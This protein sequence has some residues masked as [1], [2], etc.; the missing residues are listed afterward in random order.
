[1]IGPRAR[2]VRRETRA[3]GGGAWPVRLG[4]A[5]GALGARPRPPALLPRTVR[6]VAQ[7]APQT[8][9]SRLRPDAELS[10]HGRHCP[11]A[12]PQTRGQDGTKT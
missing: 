11:L 10:G 5:A 2:A 12:A 1:M 8:V 3:G 4:E 9:P 7:T 6:S